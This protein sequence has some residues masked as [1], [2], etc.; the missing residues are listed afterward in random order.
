MARAT[1]ES[2]EAIEL[3]LA[4]A[5]DGQPVL[6][7]ALLVTDAVVAPRP[8]PDETLPPRLRDDQ[9]PPNSLTRQRWGVIAPAGP[10]GD[11]LLARIAPLIKARA[12]Q[13][14][15]DVIP[16]YRVA[17]T[18]TCDEALHW[19]SS[20][21]G[22]PLAEAD[23]PRY[24]LMLGDLHQVPLELQSA[25]S[26]DH[27]V[28]RL[29]FTNPDGYDAYVDKLLR[30]ERE[31]V[32]PEARAVTYTVRGSRATDD[33]YRKLMAPLAAK[34]ADLHDRGKLPVAFEELGGDPASPDELLRLARDPRPTVLLSMSHGL[35]HPGRRPGEQRAR[36]GAISF[37]PGHDPLTAADVARGA[38]LPGGIW[39]LFAWPTST[40][41]S[42]QRQLHLPIHDLT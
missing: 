7:R 13:Q 33:G 30:S 36:Q 35:G 12:E 38:F 20:D 2:S 17:A 27:F 4:H 24:L 3:L 23:R 31:A 40:T 18:M 26:I 22:A 32:R 29:A 14:Q 25:L 37:G 42:H 9:A 28:G 15:A 19:V 8:L 5:D 1:S 6:G 16:P 34:S 10:D 39:F 41:H 11:A 21:L